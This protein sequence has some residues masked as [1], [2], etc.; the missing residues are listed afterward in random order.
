MKIPEILLFEVEH[1]PGNLAQV[2][3]LVGNAGLTVENLEAVA[4]TSTHTQW[5]L[6]I[7]IDETAQHDLCERIDQLPSARML[8]RSDRVFD[9]HRGGKIRT[10]SK[11]QL[12][13]QQVL[14]D[15]YTP[16]VARVCLAIQKDP[17]KAKEYTNIPNTVAVVTN[18]TA[19]L[20]L[21]D[22][23]AVAGM[24]VMEGKAALF[25][26]YAD[27]SGVPI[28]IEDKDP[29]V[30]IDTVAAIAPSFGAIQ[31]EDI[32]APT[33]F[34]IEK[35]LI[36]KL[37]IPVLHDDQHGTAVVA[38]AALITATR[39]VGRD[40]KK[41]RVGQIGLGAAGIGISRLL[42]EYGVEGV[43]GTDLNQD[44]MAQL[45]S[46]G[47]QRASLGE[48]MA[49]ADIVISTTGVKGLI[50]PEMVREGQVILALTNP[51]PEIEPEVALQSGAAFA[52]D[53]KSVNNVLGFP[54]LFRGAIDAGVVKFTDAMLIA[55]SECLAGLTPSGAL[56]P[57]P[58]DRSVHDAVANAVR[59]A[60]EQGL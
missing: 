46:L 36:E 40:L 25:D 26:A 11:V 50:K 29:Q 21:G 10:V 4:R 32:S 54:G 60:A 30:I 41:S 43:I 31:L 39:Q 58:L 33:C 51:D 13:S 42:L 15:I 20:G 17:V 3:Q 34:E 19:I 16:G 1:A 56:T 44:A 27:L 12:T 24:P 59:E 45:E 2:L 53:G 9:R 7:E 47:G 18:G 37:N 14:R 38:L 55:A 48:L 5:E 28:L 52:A 35:A 57:D 6:T 22:I 49:Q 23:G 8:G